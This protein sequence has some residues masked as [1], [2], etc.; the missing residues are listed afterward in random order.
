MT[1]P[2][3]L[4]EEEQQLWRKILAFVRKMERTLDETLLENHELTSS[5][6]AVLVS[7]SEA[8]GHEMRLRDICQDLDW[9]RSRTSHQI[10]RMDKKGLVAKVKC[11]GDAR[12]VIVEITPEGERRLK[13]A[14]PAHVETVRSLIFDPMQKG[15]MEV[16]DKYFT[17]VLSSQACIDKD[18]ESKVE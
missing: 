13:D 3:W 14:V 17:E 5:E 12:G 16:L 7:L 1:T 10:T 6:Y 15:Q 9:D 11:A 2:R 18:A 8:N 4:N